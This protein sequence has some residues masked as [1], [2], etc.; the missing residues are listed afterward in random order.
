MA[1][2][3]LVALAIVTLVPSTIGAEQQQAAFTADRHLAR[4]LVCE[5]CHG[6]GEKKP[7]TKEQCLLCHV[8]YARV[9]KRT[10]NLDPNPHD[11]HQGEIEC[12]KCHS[13]HKADASFCGTCHKE[14]SFTAAD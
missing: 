3:P 5:Q 14:T 9:A 8:S 2:A 13:G 6:S 12:N 11:S 4:G 10:K 7:V 1:S